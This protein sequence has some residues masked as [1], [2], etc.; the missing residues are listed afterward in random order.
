MV[1][2]FVYFNVELVVAGVR[3]VRIVLVA[4]GLGVGGRDFVVFIPDFGG[5]WR[6]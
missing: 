5:Y 2:Q 3:P 4:G 6:I 1:G